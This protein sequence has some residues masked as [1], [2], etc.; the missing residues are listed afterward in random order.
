VMA[1]D[2]RRIYTGV[3]REAAEQKLNRF[4]EKWDGKF[5]SIAAM[6]RRNWQRVAVCFACPEE[7]RRVIYTT[8]VIE[9]VNMSLR[10]TIKNRGSFPTDESALKLIY[11]ALE[12]ISENGR[13]RFV[14]GR[15]P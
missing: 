3:T 14:S 12:N 13:C 15:R 2:L 4:A 11:L 9:S 10:K 6:W 5:A 8:T 1:A 7:I